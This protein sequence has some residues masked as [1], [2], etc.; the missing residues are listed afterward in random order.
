MFA[1]RQNRDTLRRSLH[2]PQGPWHSLL[3]AF[4][5]MVCQVSFKPTSPPLQLPQA[6]RAV[7]FSI[8][9]R[10]QLPFA[11]LQNL[12]TNPFSSHEPLG[13][14]YSFLLAFKA[15]VFA[16]IQNPQAIPSSSHEPFGP[17][18]SLLLYTGVQGCCLRGLKTRKSSAAAPTS[19]SGPDILFL[20]AFKAAVCHASKHA[21]HPLQL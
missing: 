7:A 1:R 13:P 19:H 8:Y 2:G 18:H 4:K 11:R 14:K 6:I 10:S 15:A 12:Q 20:R 3:L 17:W 16:K 21:S 9:W 5:T